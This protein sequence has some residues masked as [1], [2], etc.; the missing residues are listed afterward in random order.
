[1]IR[2]LA[3]LAGTAVLGAMALAPAEEAVRGTGRA[4]VHCPNGNNE[5]FVTPRQLRIALGDSVEWRMAGPTPSDSIIIS[6]K[7][8]T[9]VWPFDSTPP[10]G[11][12]N[13][14]ANRARTRGTYAYGVS[15]LCREQGGPPQRVYID[16]DIIVE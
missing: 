2:I 15:L 5:G 6:L 10:R 9:Q 1:M 12:A 7:D 14:R 8:T 13:A 4:Q 3:C 16:P 11:G